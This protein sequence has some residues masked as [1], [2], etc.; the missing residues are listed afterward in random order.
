[1]PSAIVAAI[2]TRVS[3]QR[4][5][6]EG[7]SLAAQKKDCER[8]VESRGWTLGRVYTDEG[9]SG[10]KQSRPELDALTAA[11]RAGEVGVLVSPWM[12]RIGRS[13][14]HNQALYE[15]FDSAGIKLWTADGKQYD[16]DSAAGK[17][18]RNAMAMAAQF[19]RDSISERV[20]ASNPGKAERGSYH[21]GP[22]PFGYELGDDGGLVICESE[23]KW[24]RL[25][26][27]RYAYEG[28]SFHALAQEFKREGVA[29]RR[30]GAWR[31][32]S[33]SLR[34]E[35]D[36]YIGK[37]SGGHDG[38]HT[39]L[40]DADTWSAV[41]TRLAATKALQANGRGKRSANHLL[42]H[43]M[44]KCSCGVTMKPAV[45]QY[46]KMVYKCRAASEGIDCT[47]AQK[48]L[49]QEKI[50]GALLTYLSEHVIS[51]GLTTGELEAERTRATAD[52]KQA[53]SEA[54]RTIKQTQA[55]TEAAEEKW[56]D[57]KISDKR[58]GELQQKFA[59]ERAA[60]EG[61]AAAADA[62]LGALEQPDT[63]ALEAV[64]RLRADIG[65]VAKDGS[66]QL[67]SELVKRLYERVELVRGPIQTAAHEQSAIDAPQ[68]AE[69]EDEPLISFEHKGCTYALVPILRHELAALYGSDPLV[70][71]AAQL[72]Q[73][74]NNGKPKYGI[75][76]MR[77]AAKAEPRSSVSAQGT[78]GTTS[79]PSSGLPARSRP[80]R[81]SG[82]TTSSMYCGQ[83]S[84]SS[85]PSAIS[86]AKRSI[87]GES[88]AM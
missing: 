43:G 5:V 17:L 57:D 16:G 73:K 34:L 1:M 3:S 46:G 72:Q 4:Q 45:Y 79:K 51:P 56:L 52:A 36:I 48:P 23:A 77:I 20:R 28:A 8:F 41:Q 64:E 25:M 32:K 83:H 58:W 47:T 7:H 78:A 18:T 67:Y 49:P 38:K 81:T 88:A 22:V 12:D 14:A 66:M 54:E 29:T 68:A 13:A 53:K 61:E 9:V 69:Y 55:R 37:V 65:G 35:N 44:L 42:D 26:F 15:L 30:G 80:V 59:V 24:L 60:A 76:S 74:A 2:Y 71:A 62:T 19:E 84:H 63:A 50:D 87:A 21:G 11:I 6:D 70:G 10:G 31:G 39:P 40:I 86:P 33:I 75:S 27:K 82:I 85:T